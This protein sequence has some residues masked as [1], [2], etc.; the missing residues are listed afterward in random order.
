M[1]RLTSETV[2]GLRP[3]HRK[4]SGSGSVAF[5]RAVLQNKLDQIQVP[6]LVAEQRKGLFPS[7]CIFGLVF[8]VRAMS[9]CQAH[10]GA[11]HVLL[12]KTVFKYDARL[13]IPAKLFVFFF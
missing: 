12:L 9:I 2:S 4:H 10:C 8:C 11:G 1:S 5:P 3:E 13:I 6:A 7:T